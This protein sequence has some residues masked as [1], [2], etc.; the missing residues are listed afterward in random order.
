[1]GFNSASILIVSH[2]SSSCYKGGKKRVL[3]AA[4][5]QSTVNPSDIER[6]KI[7]STKL[8]LENKKPKQNM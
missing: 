3:R 7:F 6:E 2:L 5:V 4:R 1:M 8:Q